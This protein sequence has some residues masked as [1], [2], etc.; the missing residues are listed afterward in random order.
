MS[1]TG[2]FNQ[3]IVI[4]GRTSY[5]AQGR[6]VVGAGVSVQGRLQPKRKTIFLPNQEVVSLMGIAYVPA[7]TTVNIGD[8]ITYAGVTYKVFNKYAVPDG[9]GNTNHIKLELT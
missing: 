1:V 3:T 4:Y 5:N 2:L 8:R 9:N 7:N 6:E